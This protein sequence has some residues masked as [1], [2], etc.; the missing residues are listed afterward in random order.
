M[1]IKHLFAFVAL[2]TFCSLYARTKQ[3]FTQKLIGTP[4][5]LFT[6]EALFPDG[7]IKDFALADYLG[8]NIVIYFYPMDNSPGCTLQ[9]KRFRDEMSKLQKHNIVL[10]GVSKDSMK[11]HK[12]FQAALSLPYPLIADTPGRNSIAKKYNAA[13]FLIGKRVTF[14]VGK[15]GKI[16]QV[17]D[18]IDIQHQVDD[19]IKAFQERNAL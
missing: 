15:N 14:L 7:T 3:S 18:H 13:R 9:A 8:K 12:K 17:F 4:A 2:I 6:G 16:L 11:S 10:V 19:I 5:P 1:N